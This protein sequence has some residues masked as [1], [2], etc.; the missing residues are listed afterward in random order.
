MVQ[1]QS[2]NKWERRNRRAERRNAERNLPRYQDVYQDRPPTHEGSVG[3]YIYSDEGGPLTSLP[4]ETREERQRRRR[5]E[6]RL[7]TRGKNKGKYKRK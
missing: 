2:S 7:I 4:L 5:R 1:H 3:G 6:Q